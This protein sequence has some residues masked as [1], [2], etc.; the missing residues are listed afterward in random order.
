MQA[1]KLHT[2]ISATLL[3]FLM[4]FSSIGFSMDVHYCMGDIE[5]IAFFGNK[6]TC[7]M[8]NMGAMHCSKDDSKSAVKK[9]FSK[10]KMDCCQNKH[11]SLKKIKTAPK[12]VFNNF[13][14][15][16]ISFL[17]FF[18]V[19]KFQVESHETLFADFHNY[20]PPL[21]FKTEITIDY[22]VFRI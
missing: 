18:I 8:E 10:K 9:S 7:D 4:F 12:T 16:K 5:S 19:E 17:T 13:V 2:K 21:L 14:A 22:Q 3:A 11:L 20:K 1:N 6:A 15:Q